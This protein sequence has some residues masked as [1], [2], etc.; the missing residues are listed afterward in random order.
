MPQCHSPSCRG[1]IPGLSPLPGH[2]DERGW[3]DAHLHRGSRLAAPEKLIGLERAVAGD[4]E[5]KIARTIWPYLGIGNFR[6]SVSAKLNAD[7]RQMSETE[8]D[9]ESRVERSVRTIRRAER[10][11]MQPA[12]GVSVEQNIPVEETP[13]ESGDNSSERRIARKN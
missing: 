5:A 6:I 11:R 10:P 7:R 12:A 2:G 13:E 1:S 9:P 8:F 4:I 3:N